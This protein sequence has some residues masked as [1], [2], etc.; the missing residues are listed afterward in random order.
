M[1]EHCDYLVLDYVDHREHEGQA[2]RAVT[3]MVVSRLPGEP[4]GSVRAQLRF[5]LHPGW[6]SVFGE[7]ASAYLPALLND[8]QDQSLY[9]DDLF[10]EPASLSVGR[11]RFSKSGSCG[12]EDLKRVIR[13]HLPGQ[14][15]TKRALFW[16]FAPVPA[17]AHL[18]WYSRVFLLGAM[19]AY[20]RK[21]RRS[22]RHE[23]AIRVSG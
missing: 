10:E 17:E 22:S 12:E 6:P 14:R 9:R 21:R 3:C 8:W 13:A 23:Q 2:A 7:R 16:K 19:V 4:R 11:L 20:G 18:L 5:H 15:S 1:I